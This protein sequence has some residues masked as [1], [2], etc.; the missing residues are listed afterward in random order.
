MFRKKIHNLTFVCTGPTGASLMYRLVALIKKRSSKKIKYSFII[1]KKTLNQNV[2]AEYLNNPDI[3]IKVLNYHESLNE[4]IFSFKRFFNFKI[5]GERQSASFKST[6]NLDPS[7]NKKFLLSKFFYNQCSIL[8]IFLK[9]IYRIFQILI[10]LGIVLK[11]RSDALIFSNFRTNSSFNH[12]LIICKLLRIKSVAIETSTVAPIRYFEENRLLSDRHLIKKDFL[13]S[14]KFHDQIF[15]VNNKKISFWTPEDT[16]VMYL[17]G[18]LP[19]DPLNIIGSKDF[20]L[21]LCTSNLAYEKSHNSKYINN[22]NLKKCLS[23]NE[24]I[25]LNYFQKRE[26]IRKDLILK[27]KLKS[28]QKILVF[29]LSDFEHTGL[30]NSQQSEDLQF[31]FCLNLLEVFPDTLL[32]FHPKMNRE[33]FKTIKKIFKGHILEESLPYITNSIDLFVTMSESSVLE[34]LSKFNVESLVAYESDR[35][36]RNKKSKSKIINFYYYKDKALFE[37][38]SNFSSSNSPKK[39]FDKDYKL[40][41]KAISDILLSE[42]II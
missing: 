21:V 20:N 9:L 42:N 10:G 7:K 17:L 38:I 16:I 1:D 32:M 41:E 4:V 2:N 29:S 15:E 33:S 34:M 31:N 22:S 13:Y 19:R 28:N 12:F 14:K 8:I 26:S 23:I 3:K 27:Y 37:K 5:Y 35:F 24:E 18:I 11:L 6:S 39:E 30:F 40:N 36:I 25:T